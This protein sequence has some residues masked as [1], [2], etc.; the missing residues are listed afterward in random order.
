MGGYRMFKRLKLMFSSD[1]GLY[2]ELMDAQQTI[3]SL[4]NELNDVIEEKQEMYKIISE[5]Q[6]VINELHKQVQGYYNLL[7]KGCELRKEPEVS[8]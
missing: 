4:A 8:E 3:L 6:E 5:Q 2:S 1:L 7:F